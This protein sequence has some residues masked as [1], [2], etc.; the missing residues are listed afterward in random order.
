[1]KEVEPQPWTQPLC[2]DLVALYG[3]KG[4]KGVI[5]IYLS[6]RTRRISSVAQYF[7]RRSRTFRSRPQRR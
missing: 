7:A 3:D 6:L 2:T 1:M 4:P 5:S